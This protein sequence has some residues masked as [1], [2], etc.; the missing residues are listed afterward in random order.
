MLDTCSR[1]V[2]RTTHGLPQTMLQGELL[3]LGVIIVDS[4]G[5][6]WLGGLMGFML[7]MSS[8][9]ARLRYGPCAIHGCGVTFVLA[10]STGVSCFSLV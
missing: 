8:L 7:V 4:E 3:Q 1:T 6:F 2:I 5:S 9:L 10:H